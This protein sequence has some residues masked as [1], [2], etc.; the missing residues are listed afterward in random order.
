MKHCGNKSSILK[1]VDFDEIFSVLTATKK[2][3]LCVMQNIKLQLLLYLGYKFF[4]ILLNP[5]E[6]VIF[7]HK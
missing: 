6:K 7:F 1:W 4:N 3:F 2:Y 5:L